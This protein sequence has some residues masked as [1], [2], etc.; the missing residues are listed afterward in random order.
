MAVAAVALPVCIM[1]TAGGIVVSTGRAKR[2]RRP[3]FT[4]RLRTPGVG[5]V[6][7]PLG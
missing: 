2:N 5:G 7:S 1:T 4:V 3:G 6:V